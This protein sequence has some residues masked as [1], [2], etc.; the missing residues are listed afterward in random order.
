MADRFQKEI[1][2]A[3]RSKNKAHI[4][5]QLLLIGISMTFPTK[6]VLFVFL[7]HLPTLPQISWQ[8]CCLIWTLGSEGSLFPKLQPMWLVSSPPQILQQRRVR[9]IFLCGVEVNVNARYTARCFSKHNWEPW[10]NVTLLTPNHNTHRPCKQP[11][12][13]G[14]RWGMC[15]EASQAALRFSN[16]FIPTCLSGPADV[17]LLYSFHNLE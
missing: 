7:I 2:T 6:N 1:S 9:V 13:Q 14:Q 16:V 11:P 8:E 5:Y 17:Q 15:F 10:K 12:F 3:M 4:D